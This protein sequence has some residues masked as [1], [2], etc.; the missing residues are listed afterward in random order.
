[1]KEIASRKSESERVIVYVDGFNLYFGMVNAGY[2]KYKWLDLQK[3]SQNLLKESQVLIEIKY[4]TSKITGNKDKQQRQKK[5]LEALLEGGIKIFF[6]HYQK[7][8][9]KCQN[10]G[11]SWVTYNEKMTDVNIASEMLNDAVNDRF[12]MAMLI[13]GDSDL[14]P[15]IQ[16][17]HSSYKDK[18]VFVA[19]PP[20]RSND[21]IAEKAKGSF[22][23]GRK[24]IADSQFPN[25]VI[26]KDG[27]ILTKPG[28]W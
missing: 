5:Y 6:G 24:K 14:L 3:L 19:F 15:P 27:F 7:A 16:S 1:M 8:H 4:F 26:K 12:D 9:I 21:S 13:S 28:K 25:E 22:I 10:C 2:T 17:I 18:R 23:I 20:K 11:Y